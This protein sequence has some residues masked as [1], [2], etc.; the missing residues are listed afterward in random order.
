[1]DSMSPSSSARIRAF[2]LPQLLDNIFANLRKAEDIQS[3]QLVCIAFARAGA[4]YLT[5]IIY[6]S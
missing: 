6:L 2:S 5:S 4:R 1:M 3:A